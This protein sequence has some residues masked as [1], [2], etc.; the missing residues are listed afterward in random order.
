MA[1]TV[2]TP[3]T[4]DAESGH[5]ND[6]SCWNLKIHTPQRTNKTCTVSSKEFMAVK[7]E[8]QT[9]KHLITLTPRTQTARELKDFK[10][11]PQGQNLLD[12][13]D[14]GIKDPKQL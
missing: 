1:Q 7:T 13:S 8:T 11:W 3:N 4:L 6:V 5:L 12:T 9:L 10:A 2:L 14:P